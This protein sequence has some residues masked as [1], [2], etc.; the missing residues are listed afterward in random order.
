M[1]E[2]KR[3]EQE[4]AIP[5]FQPQQRYENARP[6]ASAS[7]VS[8]SEENATAGTHRVSRKPSV[9]PSFTPAPARAR[10]SASG[11]APARPVAQSFT[12]QSKATR[13]RNI[14][15][16]ASEKGADSIPASFAP[17]ARVSRTPRAA[18]TSR[19][20]QQAYTNAP[21][22]LS[23]SRT[24]GTFDGASIASTTGTAGAAVVNHRR[25][26]APIVAKIFG[27]ILVVL[28][29][30]LA[31]AGF[32]AWNW[33]DNQLV[34]QDWLSSQ[35]DTSSAQ[36]WLLLGSDEREDGSG[37]DGI[38]GMRTDTILILTKPKRGA[39]SLI[40]I[41]RD[42]LVQ[43]DGTY[44]KINGVAE[45]FSRQALVEQVE[46]ITGMHIDHVMQIKFNGLK[47]VVDAL[48]GVN[49]CYDQSVDDPYSGLKWE[50]GCHDVDGTTALAFSRM[51]YQDAQGDFGR[52]ARQ[53]QV[54]SAVMKKALSAQTLTNF[55]KVRNLAKQSLAS[56]IVD[57]DTHTQTLIS[58]VFAFR[59]A[60]GNKGVSGT[61]YWSNPDYYVDGVGSS[62]LLDD[63]KNL[64]LFARLSAGTVPAGTVGQLAEQQ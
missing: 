59:D 38:T 50:P 35:A 39:S 27:A 22:H 47:A 61:V 42:S 51:R 10:T 56:V 64:D 28:L 44:M 19:T 48:G 54:I 36:T 40:S 13:S 6:R 34:H 26:K 23:Q 31:V 62:V 32:S 52:S 46:T 1:S 5:S 37:D 14:A 18:R 60:S 29:L 57:E 55:G 43:V 2:H 9:P 53:R 7:A 4:Q 8:A 49:L 33:V 63:Q 15:P 12:P 45:L 41:P 11:N 24:Y 16:S 3:N 21:S 30:I 17:S 20:V 25:R 58:M